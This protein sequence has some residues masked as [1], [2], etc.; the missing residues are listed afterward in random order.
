MPDPTR[1]SS[2][3]SSAMPAAVPWTR[4]EV[5]ECHPSNPLPLLGPARGGFLALMCDGAVRL[6][7]ENASHASLRLLI[8]INDGNPVPQDINAPSVGGR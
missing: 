3:P 1:T 4:P 8:T 7:P 5:L 2:A 6:F